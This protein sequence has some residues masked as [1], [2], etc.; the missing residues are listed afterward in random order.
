[1]AQAVY[2]TGSLLNH[3][4]APSAAASFAAGGALVVRCTAALGAGEPLTL[5]YG[6]QA[7]EAPA[8]HRRRLLRASHAFRCA[9]AACETAAMSA[10]E[11]ELH[12]L[13]CLATRG[14]GGALP[15]PPKRG[16]SAAVSQASAPPV[17]STCAVA[18][19]AADY[20]AA[21]QSVAAAAIAIKKL[22]DGAGVGPHHAPQLAQLAA[23]VRSAAHAHSRAVA[24]AEDALAEALSA[25]GDA[26]AAAAAASRA[27]LV[28]RR[29]YPAGS[30]P[31]AH[32]AA[33]VAQL[34]AAAGGGGASLEAA[35]LARE[36]CESFRA[37]Y[38]DEYPRIHE[39]APLARG[40]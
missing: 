18:P 35:E 9:C 12:G 16:T 5:S 26:A 19:A 6:P 23:Q 22:R 31:L 30:L 29:H 25:A 11:A 36:A 10:P 38:G 8:P 37:H 17:C 13:R 20:A 39:L 7:G 3:A 4:C 14:C 34:L 32:E 33:K 2:C 27:L 24:E 40:A 1:M 21:A 28:L 15:C